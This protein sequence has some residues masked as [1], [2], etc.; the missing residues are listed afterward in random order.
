MSFTRT[1]D[2]LFL[3]S[4]TDAEVPKLRETPSHWIAK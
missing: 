3:E 2:T 1:A 4:H